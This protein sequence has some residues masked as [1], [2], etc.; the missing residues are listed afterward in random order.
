[1]GEHKAAGVKALVSVQDFKN[2]SPEPKYHCFLVGNLG[3]KRITKMVADAP[4]LLNT[5]NVA[6][7]DG[8]P[9]RRFKCRFYECDK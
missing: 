2:I 3:I 5:M 4:L 9:P 8:T 1:L 6:A 7:P